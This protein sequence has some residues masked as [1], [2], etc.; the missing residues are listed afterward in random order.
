MKTQEFVQLHVNEFLLKQKALQVRLMGGE[1]GIIDNDIGEKGNCFRCNIFLIACQS[2]VQKHQAINSISS[3]QKP[4]GS[5]VIL[6]IRE[7]ER[8]KV[9]HRFMI[10]IGL[11]A[12]VVKWL[13]QFS[14]TLKKVKRKLITFLSYN[15]SSLGKSKEIP[16]SA[17][18][19]TYDDYIPSIQMRGRGLYSKSAVIRFILI[20]I[21]TSVGPLREIS[22]VMAE[23]RKDFPKNISL[24]VVWLD[25]PGIDED[26]LP[27]TVIDVVM[28]KPLHGSCLYHVL[29][30]VAEFGDTI[31][32]T[33]TQ[34]VREERTSRI[35]ILNTPMRSRSPCLEGEIQDVSVDVI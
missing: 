17:L 2:H 22:R 28:A 18:D 5:D 23:F 1:I 32:P 26:K 9:L 11:R 13:D 10:N 25:K 27:S 4:E 33:I 21:D 14:P 35:K 19:G 20:I 15:S 12:H 16:L 6:F 3:H 29:G 30:F 34:E 31:L 24:R 8:R 7:E